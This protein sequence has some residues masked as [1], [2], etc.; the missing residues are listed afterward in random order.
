MTKIAYRSMLIIAGIL[1]LAVC[2]A[3]AGQTSQ[4]A[5]AADSAA[6][7]IKPQSQ[8]GGHSAIE[9]LFKDSAFRRFIKSGKSFLASFGQ[10]LK[11]LASSYAQAPS[12]VVNALNQLGGGKGLVPV[13]QTFLLFFLLLAIGFGAERLFNSRAQKLKQ[14]LQSTIP[15]CF[16]HLIG[17]LTSR[18]AIELTSAA[19]FA[20]TIVGVYLLFYPETG[21]LY[22]VTVTYLPPIFVIRIVYILLHFLYSPQAPHMRI[23]PQ[24]CP[25][26][27][28]Y[29]RGFAS[30]IVISILASKTILLLKAN[31]L[32]ENVFVLLYSHLG[33][34][35]FAILLTMLW[36]DRPRINRL[37]MEN[38]QAA[39]SQSSYFGDKFK[40]LWFPLACGA[41]ICFE[42]LWQFN[43]LVFKKDLILPLLLTILSIPFGILLF[44]IG[45]RMLLISCGHLELLDPRIVNQDI[46]PKNADISAIVDVELPPEPF[47]MT[48]DGS[49]DQG[50]SAI[51]RYYALLRNLMGILIAFTLFF[52]VMQLWGLDLPVGRTLF[53]S[54]LSIFATFLLA[55]AAWEICRTIIDRKLEED[56]PQS[57]PDDDNLEAGAEGSRRQTLLTLLR[58]F[59]L[60]LIAVVVILSTLNAVG[61]NIGPLLAGAGILGLAIGFGSQTLVKDILSGV[62]FLVDDAFRVGDY[63]ETAGTKGSVEQ[64][65]LRSVKLRHPRG[66]VYTIP[67]GDMGSVQ[68]FSRDYIITK[69]DVRV[70]YDANLERIRKLVKKMSTDLENDPEI[71][72]LLLSKIKSQGVREMDD[73]AMIVRVKYKTKPGDQFVIRREV[74]RRIQESFRKSGIEFAH[75]NVTVYLPPEATAAESGEDGAEAKPPPGVPHQKIIKAAGAAAA[76]EQN[77]GEEAAG[78]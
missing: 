58:K 41:L 40:S 21:P 59:I 1:I 51:M 77:I 23:V 52:W 57:M 17:R 54:A 35:Q 55:Y 10:R 3:Q 64:I 37:V 18:T 45:N 16:V 47:G 4:K 26:S 75:R 30:L 61:I 19:I 44:V 6:A 29:Y 60:T 74:Y 27:R 36:K 9:S 34:V 8:D 39:E 43:M 71:G 38:R 42:L 53:R 78:K 49:F 63:I 76:A 50:K 69:L 48:A 11:L 62:F 32:S 25:S 68:N 2:S 14:R 24:N 46:L 72:P 65:S 7:G 5:G 70:R 12:Q 67:Y 56:R 28:L 15:D 66:M 22:E 33:L 20:L 13:A 73:S 31:G